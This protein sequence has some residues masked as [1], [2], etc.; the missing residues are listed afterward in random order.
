MSCEELETAR[1][2]QNEI[3][4]FVEKAVINETWDLII[5]D[6]VMAAVN[7]KFL[8]KGKVINFIKINRVI[9]NLCLPEGMHL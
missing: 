1:N 4:D 3:F 7:A 2:I 9:L 5:L 8:E 6:E